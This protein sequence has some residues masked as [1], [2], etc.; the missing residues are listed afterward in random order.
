MTKGNLWVGLDVGEQW[1]SVCVVDDVGEPLHEATC[2][3]TAEDIAQSLCNFPPA[4][5]ALIAL[6][7]GGVSHLVRKLRA[8]S[9]PVEMF[10]A[11]KASKFLGL[12]RSKTDASDARGLAD[13]GRIGRHA[14]SQVHLRSLEL[15][16]LRAELLLR[17]K[18]VRVRVAV[19][20]SIRS[21]LAIYGRRMRRARW[22]GVLRASVEAETSALLAEEGI[23]LRSQLAPLVE[24]GE[25]LRL[26][27]RQMDQALEKRAKGNPV[28]QLL[29]E[30][31]GVGPLCAISFYSVVD[32]PNRFLRPRDVAAYLGL[33]PRR[34]QSGELSRTRGITKT[35]ST[36]TRQHLVGAALNMRIQKKD[37]ALR[38][39]EAAL[40]ERV[41][42]GRARVALARKL[43]A[44]MLTMWKNGTHFEPYPASKRSKA[45]VADE[46]S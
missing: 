30:I 31:P 37:C 43:A 19:E 16:Q 4:D 35:G 42:S 8:R 25:S 23:D 45:V 20:A 14:V 1:T 34:Y 5:V 10:E 40:R 28:C 38:D 24:I 22:P 3:T 36:L 29:M 41:G 26:Y 18:L 33:V 21:R 46:C 11:R 32:D 27:G 13:L 9:Y 12:R 44:L 15:E 6:E 7:A 2:P 17:Q 39:W